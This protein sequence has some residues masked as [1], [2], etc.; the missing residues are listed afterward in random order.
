MSNY[1]HPSKPSLLRETAQLRYSIRVIA[2]L[3]LHTEEYQV[4]EEVQTHTVTQKVEDR[5]TDESTL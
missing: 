3:G 4:S 1:T 2:D 5:P